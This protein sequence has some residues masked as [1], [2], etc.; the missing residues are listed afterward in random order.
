MPELERAE[1]KRAK[2]AR[3]LFITILVHIGISRGEIRLY[4][5]LGIRAV[6]LGAR[7]RIGKLPKVSRS[8]FDRSWAGHGAAATLVHVRHFAPDDSLSIKFGGRDYVVDA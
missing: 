1:R 6:T 4:R 7:D 2:D 5:H 3:R 8:I